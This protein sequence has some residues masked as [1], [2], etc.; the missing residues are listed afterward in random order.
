M[1]KPYLVPLCL[2]IILGSWSTCDA[3][4]LYEDYLLAE[5]AGKI[6]MAGFTQVQDTSKQ[7]LIRCLRGM[8]GL[9]ER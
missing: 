3:N 1:I 5:P 2:V 8:S 9:L 7:P 4:V 6:Y